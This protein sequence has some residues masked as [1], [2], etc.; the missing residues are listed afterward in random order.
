[1]LEHRRLAAV[2]GLAFL[3]LDAVVLLLPGTPP[4]A[5]DSARHIADVL[6]SHRS[7]IL[8][9]MYVAGLAVIALAFFLGS[10]RAWL[11]RNRADDGLTAAAL[12][13][14]MLGMGAQLVGMLMFYGAT[15]KV[16]GQHQDTLVRAL[17]D[18]GNAGI[19]ISKFGFA[20]FVAGVC[21]ASRHVLPATMYRIGLASVLVLAA[22]AVSLFSE[23]Q[24]TQLGGGFDLVG[25]VPAIVWIALLSLL[26]GRRP[27][28]PDAAL[29]PSL[30]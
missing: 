21:L 26:L 22:S 19:E 28:L 17:T 10:L 23:A 24:L 11:A 3:L 16:A 5:S 7:E 12:G 2:G 15:F 18:G 27:G 13:G 25:S 6:A 8:V 9:G 14:A 20:A 1:M 29:Q 4:K 30:S